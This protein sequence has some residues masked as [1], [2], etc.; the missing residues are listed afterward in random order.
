MSGLSWVKNRG[1]IEI[2]KDAL[3]LF[4]FIASVTIAIIVMY[5]IPGIPWSICMYYGLDI[6]AII[7]LI[8]SII[9][10]FLIAIGVLDKLLN[11]F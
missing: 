2:L 3:F 6:L 7:L 9:L 4:K 1:M 10:G 8:P 11:K 5:A